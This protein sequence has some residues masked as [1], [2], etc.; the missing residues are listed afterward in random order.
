[1]AKLVKSERLGKKKVYD[2]T[3]EDT[4]SFFASSKFG[5]Q[6][7]S[8]L[9]HNCHRLSTASMDALLKPMEEM[10][11]EGEKRLVCLFCTTEPE[12]MRDTI[13]ARCML[14]G[15]QEPPKDAVIDRLSYISQKEGITFERE[16][17]ELIFHY[18]RGHVRDMVT[19]LER[20][21]RVG[22]VTED[23]VRLHLGLSNQS[24]YF[25]ILTAMGSDASQAL[26]LMGDCLLTSS[27]K[28]VYQGLAEACLAS[29]R[30]SL[31]IEEGLSRVDLP[32]AKAVCKKHGP[33]LLQI[34]ERILTSRVDMNSVLL[35]CEI[36]ILHRFLQTGSFFQAPLNISDVPSVSV[37][38]AEEET[39]EASPP[40]S[41]EEEAGLIKI[42]PTDS[43][44]ASAVGKAGAN[45]VRPGK[46]M[47]KLQD[48]E[49]EEAS[50][51]VP[52]S[53][54]PTTEKDIEQMWSIW[55]D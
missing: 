8:V 25:D 23:Q 55:D 5:R 52:T 34:S 4:H 29:Y 19:A 28:A 36:M 20:V 46:R 31:G 43:Y 50:A 48:V 21:S 37:E 15:I 47:D 42:D 44:T 6:T 18:G 11:S 2:I 1:M 22:D 39:K 10:N 35:S 24:R 12:K 9:V 38:K 7:H 40:T 16:A 3:V 49:E 33:S 14:F 45:F 30:T 53:L 54:K 32:K 27:P 26:T 41:S 51:G 13:K 17:L